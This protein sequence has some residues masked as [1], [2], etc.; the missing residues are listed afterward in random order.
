MGE[1]AQIFH[2]FKIGTPGWLFMWLLLLT[3]V[4]VVAL[5]IERAYFIGIRSNVNAGKFMADIRRLVS[6]GQYKQAVKMCE[7]MKDKALPYVVATGLRVLDTDKEEVDFRTVQNAVDEGTLEIIP[8]LQQRTGWLAT[9]GNVAT[10]LGLMGTIYGLILAFNSVSAPGVDAAEKSRLLAAGISTA[11]NTTLV[12]LSIAI[13][14]VLMYTYIHNKT[15]EIID[16][17]DEHTVKLIN[18]ITGNK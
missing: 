14:A 1:L 9:L 12:G 7:K 11:M 8:K 2:A 13:P 5:A 17:I 4:F 15:M 16:E 18:L 10:L 6:K 3:A